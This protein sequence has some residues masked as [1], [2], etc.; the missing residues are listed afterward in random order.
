MP[1]GLTDIEFRRPAEGNLPV[2][3]VLRLRLLVDHFLPLAY[4]SAL[5]T[6]W[7]PN[8][9]K[10]M[11][12]HQMAQVVFARLQKVRMPLS[13]RFSRIDSENTPKS[14]LTKAQRNRAVAVAFEK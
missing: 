3:E 10:T 13:S 8:D 14:S 5:E 9:E 12:L 7:I 11:K 2:A 6:A 1:P 4:S